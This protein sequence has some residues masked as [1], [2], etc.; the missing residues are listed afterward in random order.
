MVA[1]VAAV[2]GRAGRRLQDDVVQR[3]VFGGVIC[4]DGRVDQARQNERL[5]SFTS[6]EARAKKGDSPLAYPE[7]NCKRQ[8]KPLSLDPRFEIDR[9]RFEIDI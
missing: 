4:W 9:N 1:V 6:K 8:P 3:R 7:V 2:A 5:V